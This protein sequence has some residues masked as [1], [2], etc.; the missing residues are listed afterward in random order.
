MNKYIFIIIFF[1]T[2]LGFTSCSGNSSLESEAAQTSTEQ[3]L[4]TVTS[5]EENT[6][7]FSNEI[8]TETAVSSDNTDNGV[9]TTANSSI[10]TTNTASV[11]SVTYET[12]AKPKTTDNSAESTESYFDSIAYKFTAEPSMAD[13]NDYAGKEMAEMIVFLVERNEIALEYCKYYSALII[14]TD[15]TCAAGVFRSDVGPIGFLGN[16]N[17]VYDAEEIIYF[18]IIGSIDP[19]ISEQLNKCLSLIDLN[20]EWNYYH[21]YKP[22]DPDETYPAVVE[23]YDYDHVL[24]LD[25]AVSTLSS[26]K[27][28]PSQKIEDALLYAELD[29]N[30]AKENRRFLTESGIVDYW[31]ENY[32]WKIGE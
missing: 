10:N 30:Y 25:N 5:E 28:K 22:Y 17:T 15:G 3:E 19:D 14:Y 9:K 8:T 7:A 18:D 21:G 6:E 1:V 29:N 23:E 11:S 32:A 26:Y 27:V 12:A 16:F 24:F 2:V 31:L 20:S 13:V 4:V